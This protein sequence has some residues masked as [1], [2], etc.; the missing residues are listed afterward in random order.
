MTEDEAA[1]R[2][3][4]VLTAA[5]WCFLNFGFGKTSFEDIAKRAGLSRTLLYRTFASKDDIYSAVFVD[6]LISRHPAAKKAANGPGSAYERLLSV[7][8]LMTLEPWAEIVGTPMGSEFLAACERIDPESEAVYRKIVLESV[9]AI[10][11]DKPSSEVFLLALDGLL[12]DQPSMKV[13]EQ[14][15]K[16]LAA[17]F[18]AP[19]GRG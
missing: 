11:R 3:A 12:S 4:K 5:R 10:L 14:R 9:T 17:R 13:L 2:R 1:A 19:S 18:A 8:R 7:C 16:I 6:W 15:T